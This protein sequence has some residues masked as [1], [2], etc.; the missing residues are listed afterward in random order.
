LKTDNSCLLQKRM[1]RRI[2][3]KKSINNNIL[4]L[5]HGDGIC[6]QG[7]DNINVSGIDKKITKDGV[8]A[9]AIKM[10]KSLD[11]SRYGIIDVDCYGIPYKTIKQLF[12]NSTIKNDTII[13]Y[14]FIQSIYGSSGKLLLQLGIT[15]KQIEMIPTI[16]R[17]FAF[18][19]FEQFLLVNNIK[20][21]YI[22]QVNENKRYGYFKYK[23]RS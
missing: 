2:A 3:L 8:K 16:F 23:K 9:D 4:D 14:T 21:H 17:K 10:I 20:K 12:D 6:W 5:Y 19:A 13:I 7:I 18:I 11:L 1:I 22:V 15:K